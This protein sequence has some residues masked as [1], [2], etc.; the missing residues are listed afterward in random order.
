MCTVLP[1]WPQLATLSNCVTHFT[2]DIKPQACAC[3]CIAD[4]TSEPSRHPGLRLLIPAPGD[5]NCFAKLDAGL[6]SALGCSVTK[7]THTT[8]VRYVSR[9]A[10]GRAGEAQFAAG[11]ICGVARH[12]GPAGRCGHRG[13]TRS[14]TTA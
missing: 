14:C 9:Y 11:T 1:G 2:S 8:L 13:L 7:G 6:L 5:S 12:A 3:A 4:P 10:A